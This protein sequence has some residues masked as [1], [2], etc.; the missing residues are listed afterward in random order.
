MQE[1]LEEKTVE[2]SLKNYLAYVM[3]T[4]CPG[5]GSLNNIVSDILVIVRKKLVI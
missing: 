3:G 4:F 5:D 2:D 1:F